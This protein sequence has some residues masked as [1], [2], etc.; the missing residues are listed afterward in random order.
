[1]EDRDYAGNI[2][3]DVKGNILTIIIDLSKSL[4]RSKSGKSE[5]IASSYGA[6]AVNGVKVNLNVYK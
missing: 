5:I 3:T 6:I 1:M 4:G 2:Q